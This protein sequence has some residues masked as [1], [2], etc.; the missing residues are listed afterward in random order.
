MLASRQL[1]EAF[2]SSA[3]GYGA[4]GTH[5]ERRNLPDTCARAPPSQTPYSD[6]G[7]AIAATVATVDM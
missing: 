7:I 4:D 5:R 6:I 2:G 3:V 1:V